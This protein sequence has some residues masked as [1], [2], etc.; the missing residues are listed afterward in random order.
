[1]VMVRT[2][3]KIK[4]HRPLLVDTRS[5][6]AEYPYCATFRST[7]GA[8]TFRFYECATIPNIELE[9]EATPN[10]A[11]YPTASV[12]VNTITATYI[13]TSAVTA[14]P[15]IQNYYD[16]STANQTNVYSDKKGGLSK[17]ELAGAIVGSVSAA[18]AIVTLLIACCK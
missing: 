10:A 11:G 8:A 17:G 15:I 14:G 1:M 12:Q 3:Q 16:N 13:A 9:V 5:S 18:A 2:P 7:N 6:N 4:C